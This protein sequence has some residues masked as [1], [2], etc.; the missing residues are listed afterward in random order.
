MI[1]KPLAYLINKSIEDGAFPEAFKMAEITPIYKSGNKADPLNYRP[2]SIISN[3]AKIFEKIIKQRINDYLNKYKIL[4]ERQYGFRENKSTAD[5]LSRLISL[6]NNSID[7]KLPSLCIFV[8]LAKAFDT[9]D[10]SKLLNCLEC[11]GIRGNPLKLLKSYLCDR[12]QC[13]KI[14]DHMSYVQTVEYG[15][16]QGTVLGPLLFNVYVNDLFSLKTEGNVIAFA[17]DTAIFYEAKDW[18]QLKQIV[19]TDLGVVFNFFDERCLTVNLDKTFYVPFCS[20]SKHL[21]KYDSI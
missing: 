5:A 9:V 15:V 12:K 13:V 7:R 3:F 16:P 8:D 2:I 11:I 14:G 21:P 1:S 20:Y 18:N 4:S 19:E 6:V 17:D 10:H